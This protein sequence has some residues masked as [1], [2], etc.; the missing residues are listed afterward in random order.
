[1]AKGKGMKCWFKQKSVLFSIEMNSNKAITKLHCWTENHVI[2]DLM[3]LLFCFKVFQHISY[4]PLRL[5][6]RYSLFRVIFGGMIIVLTN[7]SITI[8]S[9]SLLSVSV[10][11]STLN[12]YWKHCV[13]SLSITRTMKWLHYSSKKSILSPVQLISATN[14]NRIKY[15]LGPFEEISWK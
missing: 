4:D 3:L 10:M 15:Y 12:D 8:H 2:L 6:G 13:G 1:M 11:I 14:V 5:R 9:F 7:K